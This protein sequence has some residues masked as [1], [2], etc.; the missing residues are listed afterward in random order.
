M[1][2]KSIHEFLSKKDSA[3]ERNLFGRVVKTAFYVS[4]TFWGEHY[5]FF[6]LRAKIL[7]LRAGKLSAVLSKLHTTC[8]EKHFGVK[9][10]LKKKCSSSSGFGKRP[11]K[12]STQ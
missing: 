1:K 9:F 6:G 3:F 7:G 5:K 11:E 4:R 10:F 2:T 8:R 12:K